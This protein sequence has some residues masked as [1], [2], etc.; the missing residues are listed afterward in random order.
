MIILTPSLLKSVDDYIFL[1]QLQPQPN[2]DAKVHTDSQCLTHDLLDIDK[3]DL[4]HIQQVHSLQS[5]LKTFMRKFKGVATKHL[6]H[7]LV[8]MD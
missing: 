2:E 6:P 5:S 8:Q 4:Y 7:L 3:K 1:W